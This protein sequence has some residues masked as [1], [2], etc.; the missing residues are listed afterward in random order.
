MEEAVPL[1]LRSRERGREHE[2]ERTSSN[3][4]TSA[5]DESESNLHQGR[6]TGNQE[7]VISFRGHGFIP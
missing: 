1:F 5:W 6:A 3:R 4:I 7:V 2:Q